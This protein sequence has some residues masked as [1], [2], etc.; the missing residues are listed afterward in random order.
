MVFGDKHT[1]KIIT[2]YEKLHNYAI[3]YRPETANN[4]KVDFIKL[5]RG[6][7]DY[8]AMFIK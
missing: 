7:P 3:E 6:E 2:K 5:I 1:L 4:L 8:K